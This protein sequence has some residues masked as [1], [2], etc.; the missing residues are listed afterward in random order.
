MALPIAAVL[1]RR[2]DCACVTARLCHRAYTTARPARCS[3]SRANF[4]AV[5]WRFSFRAFFSRA[6]SGRSAPR[7]CATACCAR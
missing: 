3:L 6:F 2:S 7:R 1:L 5:M 4:Q